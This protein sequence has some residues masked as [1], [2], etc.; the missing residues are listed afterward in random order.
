MGLGLFYTIGSIV[1]Y[2]IKVSGGLYCGGMEIAA[3]RAR[4]GRQGISLLD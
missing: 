2:R 1:S 3:A 4:H